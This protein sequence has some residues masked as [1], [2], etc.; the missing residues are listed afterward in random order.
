MEFDFVEF[1]FLTEET[2]QGLVFVG[3]DQSTRLYFETI[4]K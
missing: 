2:Q 3:E 4:H 1:C